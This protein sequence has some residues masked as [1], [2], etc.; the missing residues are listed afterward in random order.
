MVN[1]VKRFGTLVAVDHINMD[2]QAGAF[3][4]LLGPN[5]AGKSTTIHMLTGLCEITEGHIEV[6]GKNVQSD[7]M[8]CRRHIGLAPQEFN[9]DRFFNIQTILEFQAGYFGKSVKE[10]RSKAEELLHDLGL[11]E[12]RK[13]RCVSLSGGMKRRLLL[14]KAM[15]HDPDILIL[16]EPTAGVDVELRYQFW[17]Y[18]RGLNKR[19]KTII[20]TTHYLEEAQQLCDEIKFIHHGRVIKEGTKAEMVGEENNLEYEFLRETGSRYAHKRL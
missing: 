14:A 11:W 10:A 4:G 19:G 2:I 12:K 13:E 17:D 15:V 16:D 1:L 6:Y 8:A 3:V 18:L 20:L 5:G 7:Y 9:F